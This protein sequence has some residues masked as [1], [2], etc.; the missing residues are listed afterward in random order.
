MLKVLNDPSFIHEVVQLKEEIE[1]FDK[2]D[3]NIIEITEDIVN[4]DN[5]H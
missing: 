4:S 3:C 1:N 5:T 2:M